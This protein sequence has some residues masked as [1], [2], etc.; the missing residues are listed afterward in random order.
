[1]QRKLG[2]Q[3]DT[4]GPRPQFTGAGQRTA[5]RGQFSPAMWGSRIKLRFISLRD[6]YISLLRHLT[7]PCWLFKL[8]V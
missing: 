4:V 3:D 7:G 2:K 1:M 8:K 5:Y 6:K